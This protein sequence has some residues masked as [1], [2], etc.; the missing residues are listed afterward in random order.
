MKNLYKAKKLEKYLINRTLQIKLSGMINV[1][2]LTN[3]HYIYKTSTIAI[4]R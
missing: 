3:K 4:K 2:K 1:Y